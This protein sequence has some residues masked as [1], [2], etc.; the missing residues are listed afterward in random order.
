MHA[1]LAALRHRA[2]PLLV[3]LVMSTGSGAAQV[4]LAPTALFIDPQSHFGTF[5][6]ANRGDQIQEVSVDFAFGYPSADSTG[7]A[8]MEY[9][10][11]E[12]AA[13]YSIA[14]WLRGFPRAFTL[15]PGQRQ[16]VRL[17]MR[18]PPGLAD[19][20]YWARIKVTSTPQTPLAAPQTAD[21]V[22][23]HLAYR[24]EQV[25][26]AFYKKGDPGTGLDVRDVQIA[27]EGDDAVAR[28]HVARTGDAPFLGTVV[29]ALYDAQGH[30]V[31]EAAVMT[32]VYFDT[33]EQVRLPIEGLPAGPY[34]AEV[35]FESR[36]RDIPGSDLVQMA[37]VA[38]RLPF[39]L[40]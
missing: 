5:L 20:M 22:S 11:S 25:I 8:F 33:V 28:V 1:T 36:R 35:R 21:A 31:R 4:A 39:T 13:R 38:Q 7:R 10:D 23:T 6:V 40:R 2:G 24:F 16:V 37:P 17:Q 15:A 29:L 26:A 34:T 14:G 9:G 19:G 3:L 12:A 18:P 27:A 32:S 30:R